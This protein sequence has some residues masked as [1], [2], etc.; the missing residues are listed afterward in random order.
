MGT[1]RVESEGDFVLN[2]ALKNYA[3]IWPTLD[4]YEI[5]STI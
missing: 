5:C 1:V 3:K 4:L 2:N